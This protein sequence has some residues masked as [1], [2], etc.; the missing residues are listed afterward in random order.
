MSVFAAGVGTPRTGLKSPEGSKYGE[1][2]RWVIAKSRGFEITSAP[3]FGNAV[4]FA[5][6][7][8]TK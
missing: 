8:G 2:Q 5:T 7:R 6:H 3:R 1:F 4:K